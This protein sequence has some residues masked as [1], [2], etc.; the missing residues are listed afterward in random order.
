MKLRRDPFGTGKDG[1]SVH[2]FVLAN[3]RGV[4]VELISWGATLV[5]WRAPDRDGRAGDVVLGFDALET[6]LAP[7]PHLGS[8]VGRCAN[9]IG[10]ARFA[11]DGVEHRL[12]PNVPPHHL[13]GGVRGFHDVAWRAEEVRADDRVGVRFRYGSPDG[14][15]GYPGSVDAAAT[16]TLDASGALAIEYE[17]VTD[18]PTIVNLSHHSYWNLGDGGASEVLDHELWL[19][20]DAYTPLGPGLI[21][22]GEIAPVRGTPMDFTTPR[23]IGDRIALVGTDPRGYDH[24]Y[25]LRGARGTL[26]RV[27]R[28]REP[29]SGRVLEVDTTEAGLQV[30]TGNFLDGTLVGRSGTRYRKHA[31]LCLETQTFPDSPNHPNFPPAV[32]RPGETYRHR[33][34]YR[35]FAP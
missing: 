16:H 1:S 9:R 22:T 33:V 30:Y 7:H 21:P 14:E 24:N 20:A 15:E 29:R 4:E 28:V 6:Y 26:R 17:A 19:D 10:G 31:G 34:V 3:G 11:L 12:T 13:H 18:R 5:R 2:R 25:A 35:V 32:L 23:R 8:T 27:A